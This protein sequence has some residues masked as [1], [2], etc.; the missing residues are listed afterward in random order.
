[1]ATGIHK[2]FTK[3][4]SGRH[5]F[6]S[7]D[8]YK[9]EWEEVAEDTIED[10]DEKYNVLPEFDRALASAQRRKEKVNKIVVRGPPVR[11]L[12]DTHTFVEWERNKVIVHDGQNKFSED[13]MLQLAEVTAASDIPFLWHTCNTDRLQR[14]LGDDTQIFVALLCRALDI[15]V[16]SESYNVL[17]RCMSCTCRRGSLQNVSQALWPV[18]RQGGK[19]YSLDFKKALQV[20]MESCRGDAAMFGIAKRIYEKKLLNPYVMHC[21]VIQNTG[22]VHGPVPMVDHKIVF[23]NAYRI[24]LI[25]NGKVMVVIKKTGVMQEVELPQTDGVHFVDAALISSYVY[26]LTSDGKIVSNNQLEG[27]LETNIVHFSAC[28]NAFAYTAG[29]LPNKITVIKFSKT[30]QKHQ[31]DVPEI[32][33]CVQLHGVVGKCIHYSIDGK[34]SLER[35]K[36]T[37]NTTCRGC[38]YQP[39]PPKD[40]KE[41]AN[42][43]DGVLLYTDWKRNMKMT[44]K[45]YVE[46]AVEHSHGDF[47]SLYISP[48]MRKNTLE[49]GMYV[50][51]K[52]SELGEGD[53]G[54]VSVD[55]DNI[56]VRVH[57]SEKYGIE[58]GERRITVHATFVDKIYNG[59]GKISVWTPKGAFMMDVNVVSFD[60]EQK[61]YLADVWHG[62][63]RISF[64]VAPDEILQ[65]KPHA[66]LRRYAKGRSIEHAERD[67]ALT[68]I[69]KMRALRNP[70]EMEMANMH[71]EDSIVMETLR[72]LFCENPHH[73]R[74]VFL[75]NLRRKRATL[76]RTIAWAIEQHEKAERKKS[77]AL[78]RVVKCITVETKKRAVG[79]VLKM[80]AA[81]KRR[82][83]CRRRR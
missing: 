43:V 57:K 68:L 9:R 30:L 4:L 21:A 82:K 11:S 2:F 33:T 66:F 56:V 74:Q 10:F 59:Q 37:C 39:L 83:V 44:V 42:V 20:I 70:T 45:L 73:V 58:I 3:K 38:A 1:M 63:R 55:G 80:A 67:H 69:R 23:E 71:I 60:S 22:V 75:A 54:V 6:V 51:F 53:G 8:L 31:F 29:H 36:C 49:V 17:L 61:K 15:G 19:R 28:G 76:A 12:L 34:K 14:I 79:T 47:D 40:L 16:N 62:P 81:A 18:L 27:V 64:F 5:Y 46:D 50:R 41:G 26:A 25:L 48:K 32:Q 77:A 7:D 78:K 52:S 65:I 24:L 13:E 72:D 35:M